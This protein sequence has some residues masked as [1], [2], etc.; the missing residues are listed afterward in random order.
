MAMR[1]MAPNAHPFFPKYNKEYWEMY[2]KMVNLYEWEGTA[3][4][5]AVKGNN[6]A[7]ITL[8]ESGRLRRPPDRI[9]GRHTSSST[10]RTASRSS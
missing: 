6:G 4:K 10:P 7:V 1:D 3:G 5:P 9:G 2:Q 8:R